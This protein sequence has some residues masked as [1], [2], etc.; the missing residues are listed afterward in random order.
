MRLPT[1][2]LPNATMG[3]I[4][5]RSGNVA[6]THSL[7][8]R[9]VRSGN[10]KKKTHFVGLFF[11]TGLRPVLRLRRPLSRL[12]RP[13]APPDVP[14]TT[15]STLRLSTYSLLLLIAKKVARQWYSL[16]VGERWVNP[17]PDEASRTKR[18]NQKKK[19]RFAGLFFLTGLRPVLPL[20][21]SPPSKSA[22]L[23]PKEYKSLALL[24]RALQ[25]RLSKSQPTTT[26]AHACT[27]TTKLHGHQALTMLVLVAIL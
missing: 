8:K 11:L 23:H 2:S 15:G 1:Y 18:E 7:T 16:P 5:F 17:L 27:T 20:G 24:P 21:Q 6:L 26:C 10:Q 4:L 3:D 14:L 19:T 12:D 13:C 22:A 25:C 9:L